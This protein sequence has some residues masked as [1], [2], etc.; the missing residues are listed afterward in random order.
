M[1]KKIHKTLFLP[2]SLVRQLDEEGKVLGGKLGLIGAAALSMFFD[3][4]PDVKASYI[5][6]V[7]EQETAEAY[8][9]NDSPQGLMPEPKELLARVDAAVEN[10]K[11]KKKP[12]SKSRKV[13]SNK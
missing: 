4:T 3:A 12:A 5:N 7:Q 10:G 13:L 1:N 11:T 8:N 6:R 2:E 9:L